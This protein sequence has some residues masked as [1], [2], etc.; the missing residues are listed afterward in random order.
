MAG[1]REKAQEKKRRDEAQKL[2]DMKPRSFRGDKTLLA[3]AARI[4]LQDKKSIEY[5]RRR[6]QQWQTE[7]WDYYNE[8]GEIRYVVEF[9]GNLLSK[10]RLYAAVRPDANESPIP[11]EDEGS[12]VDSGV[13]KTAMDTLERLRSSQGGQAA[14]QRGIAM[15]W[16]VAGECF[17]HGH[18]DDETGEDDWFV[19][20]VDEIEVGNRSYK[21][22]SSLATQSGRE[23]PEDDYICRLWLPDPR[24]SNLATSP[25]RSVLG[26]CESLLLLSREIRATAKSRLSA[27]LL[28]MPDELSFGSVDPTR[29]LSDGEAGDDPFN[30]ELI[31]TLIA[32]IQNEGSAAAVAP[33]IIRGPGEFLDKVRHLAFAR[34]L[35][36]TLDARIEGLVMRLARA[37]NAPV[38][39]ATGL[40]ETTFA[41]A[42]AVQKSEWDSHGEPRAIMICEA[43]T[44]GY[45][46]PAL[47]E[48]NVPPERAR[49]LFVWFDPSDAIAAPDPADNAIEAYRDYLVSDE[50]RRRVQGFTEGDAPEEIELLRRLLLSGQVR[51]SNLFGQLLVL[52][53]LAP[54]I[55]IPTAGSN[56]PIQASLVAASQRAL[57]RKAERNEL[58]RKLM[59]I[60]RDLR[61]R[62][63]TAADAALNRAIERAGNRIIS[64]ARRDKSEAVASVVASTSPKLIAC[65][66]GPSLV[67][68]TG[69]TDEDLL[70][71]AFDD[72]HA[73]FD[74]WVEKAQTQA[75]NVINREFSLSESQLE[76]IEITQAENRRIAWEVLHPGLL[77]IA[78]K[79]LYDPDARPLVAGTTNLGEDDGLFDIAVSLI[80]QAIGVAGGDTGAWIDIT[81]AVRSADNS[82]VGGVAISQALF[83]TAEVGVEAYQWQHGSPRTPFIP[84]DN[85]DGEL[86]TSFDDAKLAWSGSFPDTSHLFPGDHAYCTC[87]AIPVVVPPEDLES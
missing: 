26:V 28:L 86:F 52:T 70:A 45:F 81:G 62:L 40:Q 47:I 49:D 4:D 30:Q 6:R 78:N 59:E 50:A 68:A 18:T 77:S 46:R 29:D 41:N 17:L 14:I 87:D 79:K 13:A 23:I 22:R 72:F 75:Q 16:D 85:L 1:I 67:A 73:D 43:L 33:M 83:S 25:M 12:G 48:A 20:S 74:K 27:G 37:L 53:G 54:N 84:H 76:E 51:D 38:E 64:K 56:A 24:F 9:M 2:S 11:V 31:D 39:V 55:E 5:T 60:D 21:I 35:D 65:T 36:S 15:N 19:R 8:I 58:G 71:N 82:P 80:R 7:A 66:L 63:L 10:C 34:Q 32:P 42:A 44:A 3:S 57:R 61:I 69:L